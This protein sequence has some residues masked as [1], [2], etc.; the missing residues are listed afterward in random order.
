VATPATAV[1]VDEIAQLEQRMEQLDSGAERRKPVD[2]GRGEREVTVEAEEGG[3][4]PQENWFGSPP[5]LEEARDQLENARQMAG[6]GNEDGCMGHIEHVRQI[7][8]GLE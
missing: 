2:L 4:D 1:C 5:S 8:S 7:I 3:V 6:D